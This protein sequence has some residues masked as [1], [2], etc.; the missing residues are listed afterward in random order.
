MCFKEWKLQQLQE[1]ELFDS[2]ADCQYILFSFPALIRAT[3]KSDLVLVR[4]AAEILIA[5]YNVTRNG[6]NN[7]PPLAITHSPTAL[8]KKLLISFLNSG[9]R[10]LI[11]LVRVWSP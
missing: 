1:E 10:K 4:K 5:A 3:H 9:G 7:A 11:I 6:C 8:L 2:Y